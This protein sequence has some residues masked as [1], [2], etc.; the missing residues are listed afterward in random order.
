MVSAMSPMKA[1]LMLSGGMDSALALAQLLTESRFQRVETL[2]FNYGSKHNDRE[3]VHAQKL[4]KYY[5]VE[6]QRVDMTFLNTFINSHL[7]KSGGEIPHGHYTH[8]TMKKT[9]V[10]FRNGIMLSLATAYA[11]SMG[12]KVV[13]MGNHYG[14]HTIYPDCRQSFVEPMGEAMKE[15]TYLRVELYSPFCLWTKVDIV[16][17]GDSLSVPWNL[18][19]SC[20]KGGE[21]HCGQCGTCVERKEAFQKAR[22]KDRTVYEF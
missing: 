16:K 5:G 20:Y 3:Y 8:P 1:L 10:P 14:D 11:E 2:S 6:N 12:F 19:Y 4:C 18:T 13:V 15:G 22:V 17:K 21:K 9:V 7:L